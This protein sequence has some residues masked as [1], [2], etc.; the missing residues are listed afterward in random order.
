MCRGSQMGQIVGA[1]PVYGALPDPRPVVAALAASPLVGGLEIP[2]L[3]G[4]IEVP[5]GA[6]H[7]WGY[8][9]TLI[10]QTMARV[11]A[12]PRFG[13]ASPDPDGRAAAI[14]VVRALHREVATGRERVLAVELHSAPTRSAS[15]GAFLE[16]LTEVAG[17]DWGPTQVVVEHCDAWTDAHPVEKGFLPFADELDVADAAGVGI[18][19]NWARSV[20]ESRSPEDGWSQVVAAAGRGLL[21]GLILSSVAD[22]PTILGPAWADLHLAPSGTRLAPAGSLLDPAGIARCI[23]AAGA[24]W[25]GFKINAAAHTSPQ[26][27]I[28]GLL[29]VAQLIGRSRCAAPDQAAEVPGQTTA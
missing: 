24:A 18:C 25:V 26:D 29:E 19:V 11:G 12:G 5:P 7:D 23:G 3:N 13:L 28:A 20:I 4:R 22:R 9:V 16:S 6:R 27:R 21:R 10:P 8:V 17:W 14:D 2:F 1:Y 15:A